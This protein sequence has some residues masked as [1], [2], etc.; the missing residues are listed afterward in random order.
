VRDF[1]DK[2]VQLL[3]DPARREMMGRFGRQRVLAQLQ[4]RTQ[5]PQLLEAYAALWPQPA[6]VQHDPIDAETIGHEVSSLAERRRA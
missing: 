6:P 4:W 3:D 2:I 1:A 5:V